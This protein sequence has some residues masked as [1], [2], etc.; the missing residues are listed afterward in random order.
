MPNEHTTSLDEAAVYVENTIP[1]LAVSDVPASIQF[2]REVLGFKL[3]WGGQGD[4]LHIA[5][6]SRDGHAIMLQRGQPVA[7]SCV[8]IGGTL[9]LDLWKRIKSG[10]YVKIVQRP[11]NQ[12]WA[13]EMK[14]QDPDGNILWLGTDSLVNI[15]FGTVVSDDQL[16]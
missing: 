5:S 4:T 3:D 9:L 12:P 14:I 7:P 6:V 1:L 2:Y 11:T 8:W 16:G 15:P 13:L 10:S